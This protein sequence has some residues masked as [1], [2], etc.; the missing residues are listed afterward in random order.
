MRASLGIPLTSKRFMPV[1]REIRGL[2]PRE[3]EGLI[4][5]RE[6]EGVLT[7][8]LNR[9]LAA[10]TSEPDTAGPAM[11]DLQSELASIKQAS[12]PEVWSEVGTLCISHPL[13][14]LI[15][16]DPFTHHCYS[17]PRGYAGDAELLDYLY[18]ISD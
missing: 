12:T 3:D 9:V 1:E 17:K 14:R 5:F 2:V 16:Q 13:S 7:P 8:L 18:G 4:A 10:F 11:Y 15:W 6:A